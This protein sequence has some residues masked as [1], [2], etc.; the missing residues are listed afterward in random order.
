V[1]PNPTN[2]PS[3]APLFGRPETVYKMILKRAPPARQ[4]EG[5]EGGGGVGGW[6]KKKRATTGRERSAHS[7][8]PRRFSSET[9]FRGFRL[10]PFPP[11]HPW[12]LLSEIPTTRNH[13][14]AD[15]QKNAAGIERDT[16]QQF[17]NDPFFH[18][19][20]CSVQCFRVIEAA[21][22]TSWLSSRPPAIKN[23]MLSGSWAPDP[24]KTL[25]TMP[26]AVLA[27]QTPQKH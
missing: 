18:R 10:Q 21:V 13:V 6:G 16:R 5:G 8:D 17:F 3:P 25:K 4:G 12:D 22:F 23:L 9:C 27:S 14:A 24:P 15:L 26:Q 7:V 2:P 11:N 20:H 19:K 1:G